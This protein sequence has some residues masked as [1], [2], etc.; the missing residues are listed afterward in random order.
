MNL[1]SPLTKLGGMFF[2]LRLALRMAAPRTRCDVF[3]APG[4][5]VD[6]GISRVLVISLDS[7]SLRW[8]RMKQELDRVLDSSGSSLLESVQRHSAVDG[9]EM[10]EDHPAD[11]EVDPVYTLRDQLF[12]EPQ[13]LTRPTHF[14][15]EKPIRMS[16]AEVGVAKSHVAVWRRIADGDDE[17]VLVL[18]DDVWFH[19]AFGRRL[20]QAWT[21][22]SREAKRGRGLD[23]LY[24]SYLEVKHGA[25]KSELSQNLFRPTRGLWHLCAYVVSKKG[26]K[27]LLRSLPCCGPVDLWINRH[28]KSLNVLAVRHPIA[29][30]RRDTK[31]SNSYSVL[32]S[33]TSIGAIDS[34]EASLFHIRPVRSPVF[35]FGPEGSGHTS[36]ASALL[37]LGYRCCSDVDALPPSELERLLRGHDGRVFD[38]YVNVGVLEENV[39]VL[40]SIYPAAKF[41]LTAVGAGDR[42]DV[43]N[44]VRDLLA[45]VDVCVVASD[46]SDK[47]KVVCEHLECAPPA[48]PYPEVRDIGQRRLLAGEAGE[49]GQKTQVS[50]HDASPWVVEPRRGWRGV[51]CSDVT[52]LKS[53]ARQAV[54]FCDPMQKLDESRWCLR[55][56]T[57]T[58]N[59]ALFRPANVSLEAMDGATLS[60]RSEDL[61]VREFSAGSICSRDRYLYGRFEARIQASNVPGIVTGFFLHRNSPRQEID[62]E[63]VGNRPNHLCVNVYYN[64]GGEGARFDYGYRGAP[65]LIAL[66]FDASSAPHSYAIEWS[67]SEVRW[68]V[69]DHLVHRRVL[70]DPT[71]IPDLPMSLHVNCWPA[72]SAQLAGRLRSGR[73]PAR[74]RVESIALETN[75]ALSASHVRVPT[76]TDAMSQVRRSVE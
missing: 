67:P 44:R 48:C 19:S 24:V 46:E 39:N 61:G 8:S 20:E 42:V 51:E 63:I 69:D 45:G 23:I 25:P 9:R 38:A 18:E 16:R 35:A 53:V 37:M 50:E 30:Q 52:S 54:G 70:W 7:E 2:R 10:A 57:F 15:L 40:R 41:I 22:V 65:S 26:A 34:E 58:D 56:D 66:G 47:W 62:V 68:F 13:P 33:L 28:F 5:T 12:V 75:A 21:E 6:P 17:Y 27:K 29:S 32:P 55:S 4:A 64:P 11:A 74:A 3:A 36:L 43:G 72:R 60:V 1:T 14:D 49:S 76:S 73:L 31:S 59:L 71:P